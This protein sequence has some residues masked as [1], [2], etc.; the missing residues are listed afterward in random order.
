MTTEHAPT[1]IESCHSTWI[2]DAHRMR[3][4]R[5]LKGAEVGGEPVVTGWRPYYQLDAPADSET[6]TVHLTL[7]GTRMI[8]SWRH[9]PDCAQCGEHQTG[10]ISLQRL[11]AALGS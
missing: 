7:G 10:E 2:F 8:T 3:F 4:R 9:A 1:V 6:F 11:Q 5:I